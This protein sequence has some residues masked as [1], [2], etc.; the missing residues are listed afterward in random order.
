MV[1]LHPS[2]VSS[3][4]GHPSHQLRLPEANTSADKAEAALP[5]MTQAQTSCNIFS[6]LFYLGEAAIVLSRVERRAQRPH[7]L[8]G[9]RQGHLVEEHARDTVAI[10]FGKKQQLAKGERGKKEEEKENQKMNMRLEEY[11]KGN[12]SEKLLGRGVGWL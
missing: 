7:L 10:I 2:A 12:G 3:G 9:G 5:F 4:A 1:E 6:F 11:V 8:I